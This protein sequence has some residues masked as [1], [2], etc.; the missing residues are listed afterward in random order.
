MMNKNEST[1]NSTLM[2]LKEKLDDK[3][4][5]T[6]IDQWGDTCEVSCSFNE[7]LSIDNLDS[8]EEKY[9]WKLPQD[10]RDLLLIH[11]GVW[12]WIPLVFY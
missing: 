5:T 7:P 11:N 1:I 9:T 6:I 8:F 4:E 2:L 3:L 12:K 10:Y